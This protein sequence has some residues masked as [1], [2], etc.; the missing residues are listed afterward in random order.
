VAQRVAETRWHPSQIAEFEADGS[1]LWRARISGV[2]EVRSW[3]LGWGADAEVLK[4]D[5]L[6]GWVAEQ[7][8]RAAA[9]YED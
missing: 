3:V 5:E 4:P 1:L 9:R 2:L 8:A 7:L 6:R